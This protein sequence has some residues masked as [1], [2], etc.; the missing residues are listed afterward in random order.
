MWFQSPICG[1]QC[2]SGATTGVSDRQLIWY[3][4]GLTRV[5]SQVSEWMPD[6]PEYR[7]LFI[8][9]ETLSFTYKWQSAFIS[10]RLFRRCLTLL[11][12]ECCT[13]GLTLNWLGANRHMSGIRYKRNRER[14]RGSNWSL[15]I[16]Q[17]WRIKKSAPAFTVKA[18]HFELWSNAPQ[19]CWCTPWPIWRQLPLSAGSWN[20]ERWPQRHCRGPDRGWHIPTTSWSGSLR[21][22][23]CQSS[24]T[25]SNK[26]EGKHY[27]PIKEWNLELLQKP[28]SC[29]CQRNKSP[30][31][32][33][34]HGKVFWWR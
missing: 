33:R 5:R 6:I 25:Q 14:N 27:A 4:S 21:P 19:N 11:P 9:L 34:P 1:V 12:Y 8:T 16:R 22:V 18:A 20:G 10:Q 2:S 28:I 17:R 29:Q 24:Q 26:V 31:K 7:I 30:C 15:A 13:L 23:H 32:R 3:E